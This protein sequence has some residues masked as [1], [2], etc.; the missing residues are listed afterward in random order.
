MSRIIARSLTL[1]S[2]GAV[3]TGFLLQPYRL[4]RVTGHSM[5]PTYHDGEL[6]WSVQDPKSLSDG[7]VIVIDTE[8]GPI[9]KR[10]ARVPGDRYLEANFGLAGWKE[11]CLTAGGM[12][13]PKIKCRWQVVPADYIYVLGDNLD[14]SVDSRLMGLIRL[15]Q[16]RSK[17][18]DQKPY[19]V[20]DYAWLPSVPSAA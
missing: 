12:P 19:H 11:V 10:V 7:D 14:C 18:V 15:S 1:L 4:V 17:L 13:T 6:T 20:P 9:V 8:D 2:L 3:S 16:V 5:E